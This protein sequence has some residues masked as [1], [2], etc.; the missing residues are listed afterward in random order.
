MIWF[1]L[2][3]MRGTLPVTITFFRFVEK[4]KN[5]SDTFFVEIDENAGHEVTEFMEMMMLDFLKKW[6]T[7]K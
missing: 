1:P 5:F 6:L 2:L 4:M 7:G 3:L